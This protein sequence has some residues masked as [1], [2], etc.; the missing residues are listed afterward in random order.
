MKHKKVLNDLLANHCIARMAE[1]KSHYL[2]VIDTHC[3]HLW[4]VAKKTEKVLEYDIL[5]AEF[6]GM[7]TSEA[8]YEKVNQVYSDWRKW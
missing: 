3:N 1:D 4:V 8:M 5:F 2:F 7:N 6:Q